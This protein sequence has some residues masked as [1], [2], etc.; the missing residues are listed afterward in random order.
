M[1]ITLS[2]YDDIIKTHRFKTKEE[3][4]EEFGR[5]WRTAVPMHFTSYMDYLLGRPL[6]EFKNIG[7]SQEDLL[8][9][10]D[11]SVSPAMLVEIN[12]IKAYNKNIIDDKDTSKCMFKI[13]V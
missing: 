3:F 5:Y 6:S 1:K 13:E 4:E 9:V 8:K 2:N 10:D 12:I 11:W 7:F